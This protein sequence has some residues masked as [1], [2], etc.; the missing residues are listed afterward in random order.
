MDKK[1]SFNIKEI[2]L[3]VLTV[4][5]S[6]V[7]FWLWH[8]RAIPALAAG[9]FAGGMQFVAPVMGLALTATLFALGAMFIRDRR[10]AYAVATI[11]IVVPYFFVTATSAALMLLGISIIGVAFAVHK[12]RREFSLSIGFSISKTVKSGLALYFTV[13]SLII[14]LFYA[15][16]LNQKNSLAALLPKPAFDFT[17]YHFLNSDFARSVTGLPVVQEDI[18]VDELLDMLA[19]DQLK[20]QG[21][22]TGKIPASELARLREAEHQGIARQ[23]GITFRGNEKVQDLF[24]TV[25]AERADELLGPYRRY[26]PL[27]SALT[28]FFALKALT[29]VVY[30]ISLVLLFLLIKVLLSANILKRATENIE[31][32]RLT[33]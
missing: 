28:F 10:I 21:I 13:A 3:G 7:T 4:A 31:V 24:Y 30:L 15:G 12:I 23:Y 26:L 5:A 20:K 6:A 33:F 29:V 32:E 1:P 25:V 27:V 9:D 11:S 19:R 16:T 18:T 22:D 14:S 2:I 17:L 8:A